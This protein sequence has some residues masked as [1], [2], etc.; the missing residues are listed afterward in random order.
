MAKL[1]GVKEL[2]QKLRQLISRRVQSPGATK[3]SVITG[4]TAAYALYVHEMPIVWKGRRRE[5]KHPDGSEKKGRYWDP[6]GRG[7]NKFL[8]TPLRE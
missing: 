3:E 4:Y 1:L 7:Q 8:E 5:G 6:P 2:E